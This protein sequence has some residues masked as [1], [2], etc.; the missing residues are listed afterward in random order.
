MNESLEKIIA[1]AVDGLQFGTVTL[2]LKVAKDNITTVDLTKIGRRKV[3][4]NAQAIT[5]IGT[6]IKMLA[7]AGSTGD[8]TFTVAMQKGES[9]QLMTHDFHRTNLANGTYQ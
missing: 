2:T 9:I 1:E 6:M 3:S 5:L 8:L 4:G 7:E